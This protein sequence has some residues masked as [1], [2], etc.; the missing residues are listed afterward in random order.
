MLRARIDFGRNH[1]R[2]GQRL[3]EV[4]LVLTAGPD[5]LRRAPCRAVRERA[6]FKS[7]LERG[8]VVE[9]D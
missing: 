2:Q 3:V 4:F 8:R 6:G 1:V 9:A 5:A 7:E